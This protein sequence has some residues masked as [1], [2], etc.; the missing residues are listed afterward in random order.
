[1]SESIRIEVPEPGVIVAGES[2]KAPGRGLDGVTHDE[3]PLPARHDDKDP[4]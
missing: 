1:M 3:F 2:K 4:T